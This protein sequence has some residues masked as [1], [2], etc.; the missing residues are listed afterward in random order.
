MRWKENEHLLTEIM[1]IFEISKETYGSPR[2]TEELR[3]KG[4]RVSKNRVADIMRA[5]E[6]RARKP[7]RYIVTTDSKHNYPIVPNVLERRF[8]ATREGEIWVSDITCVRT[9]NGWLYL[10]VIIDMY[11]RKRRR[12]ALGYKTIDEFIKINSNFKN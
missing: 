9:N 10:T 2:I 4:R 7:R 3:S 8:R 11:N 6:I 5:A 12:S 1:D